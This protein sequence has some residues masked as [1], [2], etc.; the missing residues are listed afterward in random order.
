M[1]ISAKLATT[2][3]S[4]DSVLLKILVLIIYVQ[5]L[6]VLVKQLDTHRSVVSALGISKCYLVCHQENISLTMQ[7]LQHNIRAL[8]TSKAILEKE[9]DNKSIDIVALSETWHSSDTLVFKDWKTTS[10]FKNR[11]D[12]YGGV[13]LLIHPRLK[14]VPRPEFDIYDIEV[15]W[16]QIEICGITTNIASVYIPPE[17]TAQLLL[18]IANLK[19]KYIKEDQ[20]RQAY[21]R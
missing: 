10:L 4:V 6:N 16:A 17:R 21:L 7:I 3:R 1:V 8:S 15:V 5:L 2:L 18:F 19:H 12:G 20:K 11:G 9:V 14:V 13:A